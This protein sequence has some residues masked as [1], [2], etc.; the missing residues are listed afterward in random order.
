MASF[1]KCYA[2]SR[3]EMRNERVVKNALYELKSKTRE[4][5]RQQRKSR[6]ALLIAIL[7]VVDLLFFVMWAEKQSKVPEQLQATVW[8]EARKTAIVSVPVPCPAVTPD[9]TY[10][11]YAR[12]ATFVVT[13]YCGC[14]VCCGSYSG[15]SESEAYGAAG[16]H[17]EPF[18]SVAVD[19]SVIPLGTVLH[20]AEGR[21]YRAEDTG[22]AI[23][24]NRIDLFVGNHEE[25]LKMG[26]SEIEL[27]W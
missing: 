8:E 14:S 9:E 19:T 16:T 17:L 26:V 2:R 15:G 21:L 25:A 13:H 12:S 27:F 18:V 24:G 3:D 5:K 22:S 1:E 10:A 23:K 7:F 11:G 4:Q 20:D 6:Q